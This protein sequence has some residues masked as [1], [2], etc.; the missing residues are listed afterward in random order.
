[1]DINTRLNFLAI[2][3]IKSICL[4]VGSIT[5]LKLTASPSTNGTVDPTGAGK[6]FNVVPIETS[7]DVVPT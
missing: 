6:N 5:K 3:L 1:M 7:S 2:E 4:I